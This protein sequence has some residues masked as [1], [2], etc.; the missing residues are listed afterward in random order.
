MSENVKPTQQIDDDVVLQAPDWFTRMLWSCAGADA[1]LLSQC[2]NSDRVKY[3]GLGGIVLATSVLAF[4]SSSYAFYTVFSPKEIG[5]MDRPIDVPSAAIS[6]VFGIL[7]G[8]MIFNLDRFI[9]SSTGKGDGTEKITFQELVGALPRIA[10]GT[11]IGLSLSAPLE[12]R[13]LKAE[14][15][16]ELA[17][18][19]NEERERLNAGSRALYDLKHAKIETD[20]A[21]LAKRRDEK[22]AQ[23]EARRVELEGQKRNLEL[24]AEGKTASGVPG[25][26]PAYSDKFDHIQASQKEFNQVVLTGKEETA[27]WEAD[28]KRL[29]A[30]LD[31]NEAAWVTK[32]REN[33]QIAQRADGLLRRICIAE[34]L[35]KK[36]GVNVPL[37]IRLLLMAIEL[38]PI[39]FKLMMT[40]GVYDALVENRNLIIKAKHGIE[41]D[42]ELF[43]DEK[44]REQYREVFH[45]AASLAGEERRRAESERVLSTKA[46]EEFIKVKAKEIEQDPG[47]FVTTDGE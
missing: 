39:F 35:G 15:D 33:E 21:A 12:I 5:A 14:I 24:E 26:G 18:V 19:V 46:H 29:K 36:G 4:I 43:R 2:P 17:N 16:A 27:G 20:I 28:I 8:I 38:S 31:A 34:D 45:Q 41:G 7:W 40:K 30:E 3:Q 32:Y 10:M 44:N 1:E 6:I 25:H 37:F 47:K 22:N 9:V 13:V 42:A 23:I 11:I